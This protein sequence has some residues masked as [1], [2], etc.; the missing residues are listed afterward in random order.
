MAT[1]DRAT[2]TWTTRI[3]TLD[4]TTLGK[5]QTLFDAARRFGTEIHIAPAPVPTGWAAFGSDAEVAALLT[6]KADK[7][8]PL[9]Q[10]PIT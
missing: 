4:L 5:L 1:Y 3:G 9:G 7:R 10:L 6:A 8:R 2:Q